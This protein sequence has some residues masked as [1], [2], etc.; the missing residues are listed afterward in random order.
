MDANATTSPRIRLAAARWLCLILFLWIMGDDSWHE[1][2]AYC[3]SW[4]IIGSSPY[5]ALSPSPYGVLFIA[6]I[7][8]LTVTILSPVLSR[9][10]TLDRVIAA[11][12]AILSLIMFVVAVSWVLSCRNWPAQVIIFCHH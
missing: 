3:P 7:S 4:Q 5:S 11:L 2:F 10:E 1:V 6:G 9:G 12:L 8:L